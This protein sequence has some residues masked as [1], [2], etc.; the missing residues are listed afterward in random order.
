MMSSADNNV[1]V[2]YLH[3]HQGNIWIIEH[4]A[5]YQHL[6]TLLAEKATASHTK[7]KINNNS[8]IIRQEST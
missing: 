3:G 1:M 7:C 5:F 6:E 8:L 2:I 4:F